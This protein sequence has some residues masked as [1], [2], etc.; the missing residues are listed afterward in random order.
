M[1]RGNK[2]HTL[3]RV[4]SEKEKVE[5]FTVSSSH[6]CSL[7]SRAES[8]LERRAGKI[9]RRRLVL[10]IALLDLE[11]QLDPCDPQGGGWE[12]KQHSPLSSLTF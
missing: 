3:K 8:S 12:I 2:R 9:L 7:R 6:S 10:S 1:N 5:L 11:T 4:D